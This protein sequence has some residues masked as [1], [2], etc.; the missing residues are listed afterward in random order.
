MSISALWLAAAL[1][2]GTLAA[3]SNVAG[4]KAFGTSGKAVCPFTE[5]S[6]TEAVLYE[7]EGTGCLT[8]MW[9][10]G[11]WPDWEKMRIRVY[12]DGEPTASID[13]E[14]FLGHGIG[15]KEDHSFSAYRFHEEDPIF[16]EKGLRL[17]LKC[18]EEIGNQK[19]NERTQTWKAPPTTYTVYVWIYEW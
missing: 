4:L 1:S 9:F 5:G 2:Y 6:K 19:H 10:G 15:L 14:M 13:F 12:V 11:N 16:F 7:H 18:G 8:D 3:E 17:T